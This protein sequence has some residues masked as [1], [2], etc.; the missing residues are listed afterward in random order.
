MAF[1]NVA[2]L[3]GE[4]VEATL[5]LGEHLRRRERL[6]PRRCKFDGEWNPFKAMAQFGDG[7]RVSL[8]DL[9]VRARAPAT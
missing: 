9:K 4:E 7:W 2:P 1:G 3:A 8:R 6:R 5:K